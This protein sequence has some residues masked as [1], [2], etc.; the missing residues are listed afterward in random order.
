MLS[1][2]F[3]AIPHEPLMIYLGKIYPFYLPVLISVIPTLIGCY[4][5]YLVLSPV[6]KSRFLKKPLNSKFYLKSE[7]YFNKLP[8]L[9]LF[10]FAFTPLPFY[11]VRI[12]SVASEYPVSRYA[13]SVT[14]GRIPRY[15]IL[16]L[17]GTA[18]NISVH[19]LL[20]IFIVMISSPIAAN[21]LKKVINITQKRLAEKS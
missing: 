9:T 16:V 6:L 2:S 10:I 19:T 14:L 1:N 18:F 4:L 15:S 17:T 5:D 13:S 3:V 12:L 21:L 7:E 20:L 11:P 8:Y